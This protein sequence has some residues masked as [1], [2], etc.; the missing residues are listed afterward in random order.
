MKKIIG[1]LLLVLIHYS[2]WAGSADSIGP[3]TLLNDLPLGTIFQLN[4]DVELSILTS[5]N[6]NEKMIGQI[7]DD[8]E[9]WSYSSFMF[10]L[11]TKCFLGVKPQ[12]KNSKLNWV[13]LL[14]VNSKLPAQTKM[15][16]IKTDINDWEVVFHLELLNSQGEFGYLNIKK[17]Y[18]SCQVGLGESLMKLSPKLTVDHLLYNMGDVLSILPQK[19]SDSYVQVSSYGDLDQNLRMKDSVKN[20]VKPVEEFLQAA[21]IQRRVRV[22]KGTYKHRVYVT[23]SEQD[24]LTNAMDDLY[25]Q[26]AYVNK[27]KN[28]T[29]AYQW[30]KTVFTKEDQ[31][32]IRFAKEK[33]TK[34]RQA[35]TQAALPITSAELQ[36]QWAHGAPKQTYKNLKPIEPLLPHVTYNED[37]KD[38]E[39]YPWITIARIHTLKTYVTN[40]DGK[41]TQASIA[42]MDG[43]PLVQLLQTEKISS[44]T[45]DLYK[46]YIACQ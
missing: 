46:S 26:Y 8:G 36:Y 6:N 33:L 40:K 3:N 31:K 23:I 28:I 18:L 17:A 39:Q 43:Q 20:N 13:P 10:E 9:P 7:F 37:P 38:L 5:G 41:S 42:R 19:T 22:G 29:T 1:C 2:C 21:Q 35:A 25:L 30:L 16:L 14:G 11:P 45:L 12:T 4:D 27:C 15:K 24:N 34:I 44:S 32:R